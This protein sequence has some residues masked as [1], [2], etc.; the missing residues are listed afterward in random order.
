MVLAYMP[1][2]LSSY[3]PDVT[4]FGLTI[5][6]GNVLP[7]LFG[8]GAVLVAKNPDGVLADNSR[9]FQAAL[10]KRYRDRAMTGTTSSPKSDTPSTLKINMLW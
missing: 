7:L 9:R 8:L 2:L 10:A 3:V 1:N 6:T 5:K 4:V